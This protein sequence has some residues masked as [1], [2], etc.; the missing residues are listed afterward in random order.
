MRDFSEEE[1]IEREVNARVA[2]K[3]GDVFSGIK[4]RIHPGDDDMLLN[5]EDRVRNRTLKEVRE[6]FIKESWMPTLSKTMGRDAYIKAYDKAVS[7]ILG[8]IPVDYRRDRMLTQKIV[9][10]VDAIF[11]QK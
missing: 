10:I 8:L 5:I 6:I 2:F 7:D 1:Y 4:N 3:L 9:R 11:E